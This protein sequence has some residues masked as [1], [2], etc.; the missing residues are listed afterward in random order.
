MQYRLERYTYKGKETVFRGTAEQ[1]EDWITKVIIKNGYQVKDCTF[2]DGS[3]GVVCS[4]SVLEE[5][6]SSI[7]SDVAASVVDH[8]RAGTVQLSLNIKQIG[9]SHQVQI[10]HV[11]RLSG[12]KGF[13]I[14]NGFIHQAFSG[15]QCRPGNMGS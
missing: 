15:I 11:L 14:G 8:G 3:Q 12:E 5:K 10:D 13:H 2:L 1:C 9:N 4:K 6:L 7:L